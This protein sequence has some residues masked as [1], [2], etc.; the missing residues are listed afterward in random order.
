MFFQRILR[1]RFLSINCWNTGYRWKVSGNSGRGGISCIGLVAGSSQL[2]TMIAGLP[3]GRIDADTTPNPG[4]H[5]LAKVV[6]ESDFNRWK[7]ENLS[8]SPITGS[9]NIKRTEEQ[10]G[11]ENSVNIV[12]PLIEK[13]SRQL[14]QPAAKKE[15]ERSSTT[16]L[17]ISSSKGGVGK[18][19]IGPQLATCFALTSKGGHRFRTC[20]VD[21]KLS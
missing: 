5:M 10:D 6:R 21:Y 3:A 8:D 17:A 18:I 15:K 14:A 12:Q 16:V 20:V 13:S 1:N 2:L 4:P 7:R 11:A 19:T 9:T